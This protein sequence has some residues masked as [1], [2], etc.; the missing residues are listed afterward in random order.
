MEI[1]D[2]YF[3]NSFRFVGKYTNKA[4]MMQQI[5]PM[6]QT[7]YRKVIFGTSG[8][9]QYTQTNRRPHIKIK[10][11]T[12]GKVGFPIPRRAAPKISLMPQMK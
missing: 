8:K 1:V 12:V 5:Q 2:G 4:Q 9:I 3:A 11:V 6:G 7:R 10:V